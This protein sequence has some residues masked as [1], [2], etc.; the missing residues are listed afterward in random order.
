[1]PQNAL[2]RALILLCNGICR[3]EHW[4]E[5][6]AATLQGK[7]TYT[8]IPERVIRVRSSISP[9]ITRWANFRIANYLARLGDRRKS[10]QLQSAKASNCDRVATRVDVGVPPS[11]RTHPSPDRRA[12]SV[13]RTTDQVLL[14]KI[15][16]NY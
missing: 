11:E 10:E 12:L 2:P 13:L 9:G 15:L 6:L 5:L 16:Q 14:F 8:E 7:Y 3:Q 1:M 4:W